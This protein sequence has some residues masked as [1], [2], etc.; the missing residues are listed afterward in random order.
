MNEQKDIS[1]EIQEELE[2]IAPNLA[3]I[4]KQHPYTVPT[5]YFETLSSEASQTAE[6]MGLQRASVIRRLLTIRNVAAAASV[7][8]I[9][10]S[11]WVNN[12]NLPKQELAEV[13]VDEM[14]AYLEEES[15][16]GIDEYDLVEELIDI[17][18]GRDEGVQEKDPDVVPN[19]EITD[20]DI[21]EY[22]LEENIPLA[23]IIEVIN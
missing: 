21:I 23:T 20:E 19:G 18:S 13:S 22:L 16:F 4:S 15:A 3:H 5:G 7:I 2:A 17:E 14:I 9:A 10:V 8:A 1:K 12:Y 6:D 11:L